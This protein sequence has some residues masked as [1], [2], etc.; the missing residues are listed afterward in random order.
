MR[1]LSVVARDQSFVEACK[2]APVTKMRWYLSGR[3]CT[4]GRA[5]AADGERSAR[6][7]GADRCELHEYGAGTEAI[8]K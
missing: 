2:T 5:G 6:S 1:A 3:G 8:S 7:N 4:A